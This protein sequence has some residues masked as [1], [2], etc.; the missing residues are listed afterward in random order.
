MAIHTNDL[1]PTYKEPDEWLPLDTIGIII[2]GV[3]IG[4]TLMLILK[5]FLKLYNKSSAKR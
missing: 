5:T 3:L 4:I 2:F 1:I